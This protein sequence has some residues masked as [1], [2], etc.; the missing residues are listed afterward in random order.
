MIHATPDLLW[1]FNHEGLSHEQF[2]AN[3]QLVEAT[4]PE[5]A[6]APPYHDDT[7]TVILPIFGPWG[8]G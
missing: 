6:A 8:K 4:F 1:L 5:H 7:P 3:M 2:M